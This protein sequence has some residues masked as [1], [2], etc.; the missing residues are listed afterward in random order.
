MATDACRSG[1]I[2]IDDHPVKP[3]REVKTGDEIKVVV[4]PQLKRTFKVLQILANRVGAKLVVDY[5]EDLTPPG[6]YERFKKLN[7][8]N[9]ERRDRGVGRPT[10]KER[11]DI[12]KLKEEE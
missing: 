8:L 6:E 4:N 11:R 9:W 10:K 12:E 1:K 7:E 3:S 5:A 2:T